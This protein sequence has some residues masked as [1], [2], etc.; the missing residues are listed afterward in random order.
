[1][2]LI[3]CPECGAQVSEHSQQCIHCGYPLNNNRN[4][5]SINNSVSKK[6]LII[7]IALI[8]ITIIFVLLILNIKVNRTSVTKN[9]DSSNELN[10]DTIEDGV[11][12]EGFEEDELVTRAFKKDE[13]V[14]SD[15]C[16]FTLKGYSISKKIEPKNLSGLYY[17]TYY[18]ASSGNQFIDVKF[19][20]KNNGT[21]GVK[22]SEILGQV[23][24]IYDGS[25]EY[26][27]FFVTVDR[28]GDFQ[29]YTNLYDIA[30]LE[31]LEYHML[32]EVPDEVKNSSKSLV[33]QVV[34]DDKTYECTLR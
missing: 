29:N 28:N 23:I 11:K 3:N 22:Q 32:A 27:C 4:N 7:G 5:K 15:S 33:C 10:Q 2:A 31:T 21:S 26:K 6:V 30:P 1:M 25:Y 12:E 14:S 13:K 16:D 20:I 17:Y 24:I 34:V 19:S 8:L 9:T 18:E